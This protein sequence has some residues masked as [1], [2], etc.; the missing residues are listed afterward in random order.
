M[1]KL[2][3]SLG[4]IV[5]ILLTILTAL[6]GWISNVVQVCHMASADQIT[7]YFIVKCVGILVAPVGSVL[8]IV[9]WF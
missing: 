7:A 2:L 4:M 1:D 6:A 3:L 5:F 9:G 8:G